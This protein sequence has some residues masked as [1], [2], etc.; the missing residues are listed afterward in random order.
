MWVVALWGKNGYFKLLHSYFIKYYAFLMRVSSG[1]TTTR[2]RFLD[3]AYRM[4]LG[5]D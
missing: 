4:G 1:R 2:K 5:M 3:C